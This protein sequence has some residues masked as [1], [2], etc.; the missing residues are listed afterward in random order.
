MRSP[1]PLLAA[2]HVGEAIERGLEFLAQKQLPNGEFATYISTDHTLE[3]NARFDSSPFVTALVAYSLAL[4]DTPVAT[5]VIDRAITFLVAEMEPPGLW[6]YWTRQN[7]SHA[8]I[9]P[10]L[11]DTA[12]VS[13]VL[14]QYGRTV[15]ANR[16]IFLANRSPAGLFY[17]WVTPR[18]RMPAHLPFWRVTVPQ[19]LHPRRAAAFWKTEADRGDV[20]GV[21][22]ANV[23]LYLGYSPQTQPVVEY[24]IDIVRR[25]SEDSCDKWYVGPFAFY[26]ALGRNFASG[27]GD[28]GH[29]R[30]MA[31]ERLQTAAGESGAIGDSALSTALSIN[32]LLLW[33]AAGPT[34]DRAVQFL[35]SEQHADGGWQ[36]AVLYSGPKRYFGWGSE[37]LT[38]GFSVEA[39]LRYL[40]RAA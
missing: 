6:R 20:D 37:E 32:A 22:N 16:D 14:R 28:L 21:V 7:P 34:V 3:T 27:I 11:D 23:L 8:I 18:W 4:A 38:T 1:R 36:K 25:H 15:P 33:D 17:T 13:L 12:C 2:P 19:L 40:R 5:R 29:V 24:L 31:V 10:D 39:L 30:S 9:P 35:L 26:Y